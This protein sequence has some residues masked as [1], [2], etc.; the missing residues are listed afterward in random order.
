MKRSN[1][2]DGVCAA[3]LLLIA[4]LYRL[5]IH[6]VL[7]FTLLNYRCTPLHPAAGHAANTDM[8]CLQLVKVAVAVQCTAAMLVYVL[9]VKFMKVELRVRRP[10]V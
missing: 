9:A 3:S 8:L 1:Y 2:D 10:E 7:A 4:P 5:P 6:E